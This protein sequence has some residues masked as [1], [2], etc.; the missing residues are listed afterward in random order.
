V[1]GSDILV[2]C[3]SPWCFSHLSGYF[4][5]GNSPGTSLWGCGDVCGR[6]LDGLSLCELFSVGCFRPGG[7]SFSPGC[8]SP[9]GVLF[10]RG[11]CGCAELS[12]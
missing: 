7:F 3:I 8:F 2:L 12:R 1:G 10:G 5:P 9:G 4:S 6:R 11:V